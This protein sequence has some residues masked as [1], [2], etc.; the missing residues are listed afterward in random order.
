M[1]KLLVTLYILCTLVYSSIAQTQ[2]PTIKTNK[3][4]DNLY[5][6]FTWLND[7]NSVNTYA[8]IGPDGILLIDAGLSRAVDL[9]K[10]ELAKISDKPI[11]YIVNTHHNGDHTGANAALGYGATIIAHQATRDVL[12]QNPNYPAT[13]LPA[14][15]FQDSLKLYFNGEE[16][17]LKYFPGHTSSDIIIYLRKRNMVFLG[18]LAFSQMFP[19]VQPDGGYYQLEKSI[20]QLSTMFREDTRIFPSHGGEI[21]RK[22]LTAYLDMMQKTKA[23]VLKAIKDGKM[24]DE[25]KKDN[26]LK[27]WR[28]YDS[29]LF[30]SLQADGWI[31]NLYS[32]LD[33]GKETSANFVLRREYHKSGL[34]AMIGLYKKI[35][36]SKKRTH[37]FIEADLNAWGYELVAAQKL[38]DAIEVFKINTEMFPESWNAFDSLGE[39][40]MTMGNKPLAIMNYEKSLELNPQNTNATEQLKKIRN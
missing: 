36:K 38:P 20:F 28:T 19:L 11:K 39:T 33:E 25:A 5:E 40:Y 37:F 15:T 4:S 32:E 34:N 12:L 2:S 26:I 23:I 7:N 6:F 16:I 35:S 1:K 17:D 13:G 29:R 8:V 10:G 21:A 3:I 14:I 22:E 24:P 18:D 9:V 27:D 30:T 31:D